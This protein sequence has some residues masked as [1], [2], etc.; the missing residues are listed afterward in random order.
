M[1]LSMSTRIFSF[2]VEVPENITSAQQE[3]PLLEMMIAGNLGVNDFFG[4]LE[5]DHCVT[6][7][8]DTLLETNSSPLK[9]DPWKRRFLLET[10]ISRGDVSFRECKDFPV[11]SILGV[12]LAR[13]ARGGPGA[14]PVQNEP[15][16]EKPY[17]V[18][19]QDRKGSNCRRRNLPRS[20]LQENLT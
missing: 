12:I 11:T 1:T 4:G 14:G 13:K 2:Q 18:R 10:T 19:I 3:L 6:V 7:V 5:N 17:M 20:A 9:I 8:R 15:V 16:R